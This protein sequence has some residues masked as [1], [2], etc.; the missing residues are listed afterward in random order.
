MGKTKKIV[1]PL[2]GTGTG[3]TKKLSRYSGQEWEL[4]KSFSAIRDGD[5][6]SKKVFPLFGNGNSRRSRREIYGNGNS[7]SCMVSG[8]SHH[9]GRLRTRLSLLVIEV[10]VV[11]ETMKI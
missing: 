4:P 6:K 10:V 8:P 9:P 11:W 5:G 3:I 2:F 7:R 1:F